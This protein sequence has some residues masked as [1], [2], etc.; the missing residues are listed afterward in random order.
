MADYEG[1]EENS[2]LEENQEV[3][4]EML[5][6]LNRQAQQ[7]NA[8]SQSFRIIRSMVEQQMPGMGGVSGFSPGMRDCPVTRAEKVPIPKTLIC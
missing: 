6:E 3:N 5:M 2:E 8:S 1:F 4:D 7:K